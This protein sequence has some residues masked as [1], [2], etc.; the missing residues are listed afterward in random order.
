MVGLISLNEKTNFATFSYDD[1]NVDGDKLP[2]MDKP[3]EDV[4]STIKK[5]AKGSFA[6]GTDGGIKTL[7]GDLNEWIDY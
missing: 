2:K 3:G 6:I 4:L 5:C 1:W 7:N